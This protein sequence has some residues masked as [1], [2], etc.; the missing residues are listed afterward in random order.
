MST[1]S[2]SSIVWF[3][4][5]RYP[6]R[7]GVLL[8][9]ASISTLPSLESTI[10]SGHSFVGTNS[11]FTPI[12]FDIFWSRSAFIPSY[13]KLFSFID[14]IGNQN[15]STANLSVGFLASQ[16]ISCCVKSI[17]DA[18]ISPLTHFAIILFRSS[19]VIRSSAL[20]SISLSSGCFFE[21]PIRREDCWLCTV[22]VGFRPLMAFCVIKYW[23]SASHP[24]Y[25]SALPLST[26]S[27]H[28]SVA[29]Q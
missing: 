12:K 25:P 19:W 2:V 20:S 10:D 13:C 18:P 8:T 1:P 26:A 7:S 24:I 27:K 11:N 28:S 14:S 6:S 15:G 22:M 5:F 9:H 29:S 4:K 17:F 23:A 16:A 3:E 21:T